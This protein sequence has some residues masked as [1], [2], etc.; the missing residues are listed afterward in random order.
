MRGILLQSMM[1]GLLIIPL[2]AARDPRPWRGLKRGVAWFVAF[3]VLYM[4]ALRFIYP[5][6]S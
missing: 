1:L 5:S 4:L 6:L 2:V 3:N